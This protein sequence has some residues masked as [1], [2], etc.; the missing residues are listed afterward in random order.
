MVPS[1]WKFLD[2]PPLNGTGK[3]MKDELR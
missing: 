1:P 3:F 2:I